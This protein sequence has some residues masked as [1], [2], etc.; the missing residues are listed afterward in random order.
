MPLD[1]DNALEFVAGP[2]LVGTGQRLALLVDVFHL[3]GTDLLKG[4]RF[5]R[6]L[7]S[8]ATVTFYQPAP[9]RVWE[10]F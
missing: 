9:N 4:V 7:K 8:N 1:L 10:T 2:R 6:R 5:L 3:R